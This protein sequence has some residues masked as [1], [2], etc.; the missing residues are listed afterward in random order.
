MA[1][2]FGQSVAASTAGKWTWTRP[3][4]V[5][6]MGLDQSH[7]SF[8]SHEGR[9]SPKTRTDVSLKPK[10]RSQCREQCTVCVPGELGRVSHGFWGYTTLDTVPA[11]LPSGE[12]VRCRAPIT[13]HRGSN[14]VAT[15]FRARKPSGFRSK[16][17]KTY[18]S[19]VIRRGNFGINRVIGCVIAL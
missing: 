3:L 4:G 18:S 9:I 17:Q 19:S 2:D 16:R 6:K 15:G 10:C 7:W 11:Q 12:R 8:G 1:L 14:A 13:I 5:W